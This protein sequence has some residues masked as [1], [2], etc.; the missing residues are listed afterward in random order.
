MDK[1]SFGN[2]GSETFNDI[3]FSAAKGYAD[4]Q[5]E[6]EAR[7]QLSYPLNEIQEFVNDTVPVNSDNK[8]VQLFITEGNKLKY[9]TSPGGIL[10]N[11]DTN[12][13]SLPSGGSE[14][15]SLLKNSSED[16]DVKWGM[17]SFVGMVVSG[18]GDTFNTEAKVKAIYGS[19]TSWSLIS[20]VVLKSKHVFGNGY[21]LGMT[22]GNNDRYGLKW[23]DPE[24]NPNRLIVSDTAYGKMIGSSAGQ[25]T[26]T[27]QSQDVI[28]VITKAMIEDEYYEES[29]L[30]V[31]VDENIYTWRRTA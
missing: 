15:Q 28:G 10:V 22:S 27:P 20:T 31:D 23:V 29:G 8:A 26:V 12:D 30:E 6:A 5:S 16:Y 13:T 9:R 19:S 7:N 11:V 14:N 25:G 18:Y 2:Y 17:P 4:P 1:L 24:A 21:A 3:P